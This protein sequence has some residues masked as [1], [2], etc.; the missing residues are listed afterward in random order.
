[1]TSP[2]TSNHLLLAVF[3]IVSHN[4]VD[5]PVAHFVQRYTHT[6]GALVGKFTALGEDF[7]GAVSCLAT[8]HLVIARDAVDDAVAHERLRDAGPRGAHVVA[9]EAFFDSQGRFRSAVHLIFSRDAVEDPVAEVGLGDA[10]AGVALVEAGEALA[11]PRVGE[12]RAFNSVCAMAQWLK[13]S[14][15]LI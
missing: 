9:R 3:L 8:V 14:E 15:L 11:R 7:R 12:D 10:D 13:T 2:K 5:D 6:P 1:M 4:A